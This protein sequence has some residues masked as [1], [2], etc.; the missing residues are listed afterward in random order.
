MPLVKKKVEDLMV[1]IEKYA[2]TTAESSLREAVSKLEEGF[3]KVD[4][5]ERHRTILVLDQ[6]MK[7]VGIIDFRRII[8]VLIP[9]CSE[10][11]RKK[12]EDLG[13]ALRSI[14]SPLEDLEEAGAKFKNRVM[15]NAETRVADVMLRTRGS[16]QMGADLVEAIKIKCSNKLTV[17]PVYN[18]DKLVGVLRDVD[19]FLNIAEILRK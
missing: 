12:L 6:S 13:L 10:K 18:G 9:E 17:L 15:N 7:L 3:L 1:P 8:E 5:S 2:V 4:P 19:V 14:R 11:L 16:V